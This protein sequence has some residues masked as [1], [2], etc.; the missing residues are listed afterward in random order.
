MK[1]LKIILI[2]ILG[3]LITTGAAVFQR[4]TGP[5][6]PYKETV[7]LNHKDYKLKFTRSLSTNE[8]SAIEI[9]VDNT[10]ISG[11][12]SYRIYP[13]QTPFCGDILEHTEKGLKAYLPKQSAAGKV[14]YQILLTDGTTIYHT[15]FLLVRYKDPVPDILLIS[16]IITMFLGMFLAV[17]A[18]L[19]ALTNFRKYVRTFLWSTLLL[20]IG[21]MILGPIVQ[22]YAFGE[23]WTGIP[24]GWDL[25][26]NK[27]LIMILVFAFACYKNYKKPSR[28]WTII[29]VIIMLLVYSIP[30]SL[31]GSELNPETGEIIQAGLIG[32]A[33]Q[34]PFK[35]IPSTP[36][37]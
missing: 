34:K 31:L 17:V 29:A 32:L 14:E 16:H 20:F 26:D 12:I 24:F 33:S 28:L 37:E 22:K 8:E 1:L 6:H 5:T 15:P 30:H 13:S 9:P 19:M 7:N 21:G 35:N 25:T 2:W 3:F 11:T 27:T 10:N 36:T 23:F 18:G 4:M